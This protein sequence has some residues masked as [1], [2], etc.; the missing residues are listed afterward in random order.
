MNYGFY[1]GLETA[2]ETDAQIF[3]EL[4]NIKIKCRII[5]LADHNPCEEIG[6]IFTQFCHN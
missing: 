3:D 6:Q 1:I 4:L 5:F 2:L